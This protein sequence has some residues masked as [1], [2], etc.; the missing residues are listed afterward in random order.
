MTSRGTEIAIYKQVDVAF[1]TVL[2]HSLLNKMTHCGVDRN[3]HQ[4]IASF[5]VIDQPFFCFFF[6]Q[7]YYDGHPNLA[8]SLAKLT[9]TPLNCAPSDRL[10]HVVGLGL[11]TEQGTLHSRH[12]N[13][14][15]YNN[16]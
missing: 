8:A 7:L 5:L 2:L 9:N 13:T 3:I 1:D 6:S 14:V 4:W 11:K 12:Y 15:Q 10:L 16:L